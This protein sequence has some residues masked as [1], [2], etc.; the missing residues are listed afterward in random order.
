M[1]GTK[2]RG[3]VS[4]AAT[5]VRRA[6]PATKTKVLERLE[7]RSVFAV[8]IV[9]Y[10]S[11]LVVLLTAGVVLWQV[12]SAAGALSRFDHLV[13]ALGFGSFVLRGLP[14]FMAALGIG[15]VLAALGA[16]CNVFLAVVY[17]LIAAIVGGIRMTMDR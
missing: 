15:L 6:A 1:A 7:P 12:A 17:N 9:F 3:T 10:A 14:L 5:T 16:L 2:G 4:G 13:T 11:L 8:S